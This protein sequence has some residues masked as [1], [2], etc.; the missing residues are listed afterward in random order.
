M[1][2]LRGWLIGWHLGIL[3]LSLVLFSVLLHQSLSRSLY[4]HHDADL[5]IEAD[6]LSQALVGADFSQGAL[7][8]APDLSQLPEEFVM[9]R[10]PQ[11][12]LLYRSPFLQV[13][14]PNIGQHEALVHSATVGTTNPLFFTAQLERAGPVRFIC[15]PIDMPPRAYLQLG[16]P[17]GDV[18]DTL[19]AVATACALL[20]PVVLLIMSF[21]GWI[22]ARRA[23]APMKSIDDTLQAIQAT[24]LSRRIDVPADTELGK[25]VSTLNR[26][27]DRLEKA[28][29]S[30][31]QFTADVSHQLQTPLTVMKGTA[32]VALATPRSPSEY[33]RTLAEFAEEVDDMARVLAD[34]RALTLADAGPETGERGLVNLADVA[35]EATEIVEA[36]GESKDL[37]VDTAITPDVTVWGSRV[38]L[39]QVFLNLGDNAVKYT[40]AGGRISLTLEPH[41]SE[42]MLTISDTGVGI[43]AEDLPHVFDRFYRARGAGPPS[44][45]TGLG[46]AIVKRI[47]EVHG[48]SITVESTLGRGSTFTVR[49]PLKAQ[50]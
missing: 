18:P 26:L 35:Q 9:V 20:V 48:G 45:G 24:D 21:G 49:L 46:L 1:R 33:Q 38:G 13:S 29:A 14:E 22:V 17:L 36:L 40:P 11:G 44:T 41:G 30:L 12:E 10:N 8:L 31:K 2:S 43:P 15:V 19:R 25:L 5:A 6:K 50:S 4:R 34:L 47:V 23:L 7:A 37:S 42:A 32:E 27:L 39:K 3:A 16:R 28:F